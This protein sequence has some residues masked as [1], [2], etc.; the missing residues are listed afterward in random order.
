MIQSEGVKFLTRA[1]ILP[2]RQEDTEEESQEPAMSMMDWVDKANEKAAEN[3]RLWH[4]SWQRMNKTTAVILEYA[5]SD[6]VDE[7]TE[8]L[9]AYRHQIRYEER[10]WRA[11]QSS[12]D[13]REEPA[14]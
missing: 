8:L 14:R 12:S 13:T 6:T 2:G 11:Q 5:D 3:E 4:E 9:S 1:G 10:L 7:F